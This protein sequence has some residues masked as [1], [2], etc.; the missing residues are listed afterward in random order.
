MTKSS[1][2][3]TGVV[4]PRQLMATAAQAAES[5]Q[6]LLQSMQVM[7]TELVK[8]W[9]GRLDQDW[10]LAGELAKCRSLDEVLPVQQRFV[11][12]M[13]H[14]YSALAARLLAP[15]GAVGQALDEAK[16]VGRGRV[17]R[18]QAA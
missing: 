6:A 15:V 3:A 11:Q 13:V 7:N 4:D 16:A 10:M 17:T 5:G 1:D 14:A 2:Q 8:F 9:I 18:D 12:E